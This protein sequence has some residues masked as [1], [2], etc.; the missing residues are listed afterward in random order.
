M[1]VMEPV[2]AK[3]IDQEKLRAARER[4]NWTVD[5][6]VYEARRRKYKISRQ[7]ILD[8]ES[9]KSGG[10]IEKLCILAEVY[11]IRV[12]DELLAN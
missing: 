12:V 10:T 6:A 9:G 2:V 11:G 7:T 8:L 4:W 1:R 5:D 3:K